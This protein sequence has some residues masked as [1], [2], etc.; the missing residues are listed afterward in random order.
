LN[1]ATANG[2][3]SISASISGTHAAV[4]SISSNTLTIAVSP[5]LRIGEQVTVSIGTGL[6][7][8]AGEQLG[9]PFV[10][11][12]TVGAPLARGTLVDS[13][14]RIIASPTSSNTLATALA[15]FDGDGD[16]DAVTGHSF[17]FTNGS[18]I[19]GS[20][21]TM[22]W[23]NNGAGS[24]S[25][26]GQRL[27]TNVS[28]VVVV[29]DADRDGDIDFIVTKNGPTEFW[30]NDGLGNFL[31]STQR[32]QIV[33]QTTNVAAAGI[34]VGDLNGDG[35]PD[36]AIIHT[37]AAFPAVVTMAVWTNNGQGLFVDSG[38]RLN[39]GNSPRPPYAADIDGDG[40]L[41]LVQPYFNSPTRLWLNNGF[42]HFVDN[43]TVGGNSPHLAVGDL[44]GDGDVDLAI[45]GSTNTV[46]WLNNGQGSFVTNGAPLGFGTS[47]GM[48]LADMDGDGSLD[49]LILESQFISGPNTNTY[50]GRVHFNDGAANFTDRGV[51]LGGSAVPGQALAVGDLNGDGAPDVYLG[52]V[53]SPDW[54]LLN[55]AGLA[56]LVGASATLIADKTNAFPFASV[57]LR[58]TPG[59]SVSVVVKMDDAA[60]GAFSPASLS[61]GG[62]T[63]GPANTFTR[64]ASG[65]AAAQAALRQLLFTPVQNRKPVGQSEATVFTIITSDGT[66][67]RTNAA[68]AVTALSINDAPVAANDSGA[69]FNTTE[70]AAFTTGNALANDTDI[71]A[72]E[73][74]LVSAIIT[75]GTVGLV[76]NNGNGTF[77]YDPAGRF[78]FLP[79]GSVTN[80]SF[81]YVASD[82]HGGVSTGLVTITL[83]GQNNAPVA[84]S[85]T[86]FIGE[87]DGVVTITP[88][89]LANDSDL[90]QGETTSLTISSVT[91]NG[92]PGILT[93]VSGTVVTYDRAGAF[94]NIRQGDSRTLFINY[95]VRDVQ[96]A[97]ASATAT[98]V[99]LGTNDAPVAVDDALTLS[100]AHPGTN[101]TT[102]VL[103]ND[104]D[105]DPLSAL[106]LSEMDAS[107]TLGI[108]T[109]TNGVLNYR[110]GPAFVS[111]PISNV[112]T[113]S[114]TYVLRDQFGAPSSARVAL[115]ITGVNDAPVAAADSIFVPQG[116]PVALTSLLLTND[117]D[118]DT[119]ETASLVVSA[120]QT[121]GIRGSAIL[122]N[123]IVLYTPNPQWMLAQ[124][125]RTND[126]FS[127]V[128]RDVNGAT[129]T[130][131]VT[132]TVGGLNSAPSA[133]PDVLQFGQFD[134]ATDITPMLLANDTDPNPGDAALLAISSLATNDTRG[135]LRLTNGHVYYMPGSNFRNV[136][137]GQVAADSFLYTLR[138]PF[139]GSAI[140]SVSIRVLGS[141]TNVVIQS[142]ARDAV[143]QTTLEFHGL[144]NVNY[145]VQA[146]TNLTNWQSI[147]SAFAIQSNRFRFIDGGSSN[148]PT[149]FYRLVFP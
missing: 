14:Q 95:T 70:A 86:I 39:N 103:A 80:D 30:L 72:G 8:A 41:D 37:V 66:V 7:G 149:R 32:F 127:Y 22:L 101:L 74:L 113:D 114:F 45:H 108:V 15:D 19:P 6:R 90:D 31:L 111:L 107:T 148:A 68:S 29:L 105:P 51:L 33:E 100:A 145:T 53:G 133:A 62:F 122:S 116:G 109:L 89:M 138:D 146:S 134:G 124:D 93:R 88:Q 97:T 1:A 17:I 13:G 64:A 34:S 2:Q 85:E 102:F 44:D 20:T 10:W 142:V 35:A 125:Q 42:G 60:K 52:N 128:V 61:T 76:T 77:R 98:L 135:V 84:N 132:I 104:S 120:L 12:F 26:S 38:E 115:T 79:L 28:G 147:G 23:R 71:D 87:H 40:D 99:I 131:A 81:R 83:T 126:S 21:A 94:G 141:A 69:G 92:V 9:A 96:G 118:P 82:G 55:S 3:V 130:G 73:V 119:N 18:P 59:A 144:T 58:A 78:T 57:E 123:G 48:R 24:F 50:R 67:T 75:N 54:V 11:Q 49:L 143:R 117:Y 27:G 16:L 106:L 63:T 56:P 4:P 137:A 112:A 139:G 25:D 65:V 5:A 36:L 110:P 43:G 140:S 129:A 46:I 136:S 121:N 47:A 91:T